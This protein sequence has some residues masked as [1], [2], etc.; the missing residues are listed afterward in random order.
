MFSTSAR[1]VCA[2][3]RALQTSRRAWKVS[4]S[5]TASALRG[6]RTFQTAAIPRDAATS[7]PAASFE[8][9]SLRKS[10]HEVEKQKN[11]TTAVRALDRLSSALRIKEAGNER[12][13]KLS[14]IRGGGE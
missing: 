2:C 11:E 8:P 5:V 14:R 10:S 9:S 13:H 12:H 4:H 3:S 1:P 7:E 6:Q